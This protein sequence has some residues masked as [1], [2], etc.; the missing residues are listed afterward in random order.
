MSKEGNV[1]CHNSLNTFY[2]QLCFVRH[3]KGVNPTHPA[4]GRGFRVMY[5]WFRITVSVR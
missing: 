1:L 5:Q 3:G 4:G 2:L